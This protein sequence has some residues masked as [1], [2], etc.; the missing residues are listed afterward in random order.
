MQDVKYRL[1]F[2]RSLGS[3]FPE[4]RL[5]IEPMS[6]T[7]RHVATREL[8]SDL[9]LLDFSFIKSLITV[10]NTDPR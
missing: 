8:L 2:R 9:N 3:H 5:V 1:D 7:A 10:D 6:N 4:K